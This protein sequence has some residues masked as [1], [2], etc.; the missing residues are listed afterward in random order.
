MVRANHAR[1]GLWQPAYRVLDKDGTFELR[2]YDAAYAARI[3][4]E[5]SRATATRDGFNALYQYISGNNKDGHRYDMTAPV[6]QS[7]NAGPQYLEAVL[8]ED[9]NAVQSWTLTFHL[10]PKIGIERASPPLDAR[11]DLVELPA[12]RVAV[13]S[14]SGAWSDRNFQSAA[15]EVE[16]KMAARGVQLSETLLIAFCDAPQVPPALRHTEIHMPLKGGKL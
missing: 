12:G 8:A 6:L 14:F 7:T 10:P 13:Q 4:I 9:F 11:V 1:E 2:E 16:N 3:V 5:D 15:Q